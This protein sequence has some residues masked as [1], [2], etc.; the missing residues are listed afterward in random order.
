MGMCE[1]N[2]R[3]PFPLAILVSVQSHFEPLGPPPGLIRPLSPLQILA[4]GQR[5]YPHS[6]L[7]CGQATQV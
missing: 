1:W 5:P 3:T 7:M 6:T 2:P 4:L